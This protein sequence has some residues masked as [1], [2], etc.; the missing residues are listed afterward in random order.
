MSNI[1]RQRDHKK[2]Q[3]SWT[4]P[5]GSIDLKDGAIPDSFFSEAQNQAQ[6]AIRPDANGNGLY[7]KLHDQT[8]QVTLSLEEESG[9]N[10]K[11]LSWWLTDQTLQNVVGPIVLSDGNNGDVYVFRNARIIQRFPV[12]AGQAPSQ[13]DW[14]MGYAGIQVIPGDS[15]QNVIA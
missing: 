13:R 6:W 5:L 8:G 1:D 3:I 15:T 11:L 9:L 14:L 2:I 7:T 10:Q 4:T 12:A